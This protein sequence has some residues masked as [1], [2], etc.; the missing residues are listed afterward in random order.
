M[1][2]VSIG[3]FAALMHDI[4]CAGFGGMGS[5]EDDGGSSSSGPVPA[6]GIVAAIVGAACGFF[7]ERYFVAADLKKNGV[8]DTNGYYL[9]GKI[10]AA[11]GAIAGP[12]IVGLLR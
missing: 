2:R 7:L 11:I 12:F 6:S 10:G 3:L 9:G 1:V 4:A 5:V 8:T